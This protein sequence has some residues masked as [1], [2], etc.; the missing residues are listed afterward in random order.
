M[1]VFDFSKE[2]VQVTFTYS[3]STIETQEKGV[4]YVQSLPVSI[5]DFEQVNASWVVS[6]L[7]GAV[8]TLNYLRWRA[9]QQYL[10][11]KSR[12]LLLPNSSS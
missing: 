12:K 7:R 8:K 4:K 10:T 11:P 5:V 3:K 6:M 9:L 2:L 1:P